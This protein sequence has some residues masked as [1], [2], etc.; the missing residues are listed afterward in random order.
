MGWLGGVLVLVALAYAPSLGGGFVGD[1]YT[2]VKEE[3]LVTAPGGL[4]DYFGRVLWSGP[5]QAARGFYRPLVTLS[6]AADYRL[7]DG[8]PA[9]FHLGNLV[10]H[11]LV[12]ILVWALIRRAA[13]GAGSAGGRA[14]VWAGLAAGFALAPRLTEGVAWIAGRGYLAAAGATLAALLLHRPG[15]GGWPGKLA[16]AGMLLVGLLCKE[17]AIAGFVAVVVIERHHRGPGLRPVRGN[18]PAA[19]SGLA[20]R[21]RAVR[22]AW[23]EVLGRLVPAAGAVAVYGGLRLRA[24]ALDATTSVAADFEWRTPGAVALAV[25]EAVGRYALMLL[26]P[27]RPRLLGGLVGQP[28][29]GVCLL[30]GALLLLGLGGGA[31]WIASGRPAR[32][33]GTAWAGLALAGTGLGL[34]VHLL[35][36]N[37]SAVASDR[38]LYLPIAGLVI[39]AAPAVARAWE[40]RPRAAAL[41]ACAGVALF[42]GAKTLRSRAWAD[43]LRLWRATIES[44]PPWQRLRPGR[45]GPRLM[46]RSRWAEALALLGEVSGVQPSY[47]LQPSFRGNLALCLDKLGQRALALPLLE[48]TVKAHPD[49]LRLH[50]HLLMAHALD[51]RFDRARATAATLHPAGATGQRGVRGRCGKSPGRTPRC[52]RSDIPLPVCPRPAAVAAGRGKGEGRLPRRR[53]LTRRA[54]APTSPHGRPRGEV[55]EG[56]PPLTGVAPAPAGGVLSR[57]RGWCCPAPAGGVV[58]RPRVRG[59]SPARG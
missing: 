27:L 42:A 51:L 53:P 11:L 13:A 3:P 2:L 9:G 35:P 32:L 36:L 55:F 10:L 56:D 1:D 48:E 33:N 6:Y 37:V 8:R 47:N 54:D 19:A 45:A 34:V 30:G 26:D 7:W 52:L 16:A 4:G 12:T 50:H 14:V 17:V 24:W 44:A 41:V 25:V 43:E 23:S 29:V 57:A 5:L 22:G 38:F 20:D 18:D 40:R 15:G 21:R 31:R 58:P 28:A 46:Q 49:W 39:A 59:C